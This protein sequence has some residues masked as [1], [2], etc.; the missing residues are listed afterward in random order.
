M[1]MAFPDNGMILS[2]VRTKNAVPKLAG[3]WLEQG[4]GF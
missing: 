1:W 4:V 2:E 3:P